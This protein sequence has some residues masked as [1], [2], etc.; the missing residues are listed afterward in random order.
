MD[1]LSKDFLPGVK[2]NKYFIATFV[3]DNKRGAYMA[4]ITP[5]EPARVMPGRNLFIESR[6]IPYLI[7]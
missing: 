7:M 1:N 2:Q 3:A 5:Y 4:E 6:Y